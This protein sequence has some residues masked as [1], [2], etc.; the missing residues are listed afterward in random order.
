MPPVRVADLIGVS[1]PIRLCAAVGGRYKLW[2]AKDITQSPLD[3]VH[4]NVGI[5]EPTGRTQDYGD[6]ALNYTDYGDSALNY[7]A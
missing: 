4:Q 2:L 5:H 1:P 6:S 3:T 7:T